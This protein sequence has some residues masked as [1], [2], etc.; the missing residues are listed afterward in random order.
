MMGILVALLLPG[1]GMVQISQTVL[2]TTGM[3]GVVG[4]LGI[5]AG[6]RVRERP[7]EWQ[8]ALEWGYRY[9][10]DLLSEVTEKESGYRYVP[11]VATLAV[12]ILSAALMGTLPL[13]EAPTANLNTAVALALIVFFAAHYYGIQ[14]HGWCGYLRQFAEPSWILVPINLLGHITRTIS[15]AI[16]LFANMLSHQVIIAVLLLI[17]PL[18]I[19]VL[20][21]LFGLFIG[22]LQ[23]YIFT[24]LTIVYIGGAVRA[25]GGM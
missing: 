23:A 8:A 7:S 1:G 19:P 24:L 5:L 22:A 25:Q 6:R 14:E 9:L 17:A 10:E 3:V 12:F 13:L 18:V 11:L 15:L 20:F 16:R 4:L 21:E 2:E